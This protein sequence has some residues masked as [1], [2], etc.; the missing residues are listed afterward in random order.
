MSSS[1][2]ESKGSKVESSI[3]NS[4][5]VNESSQLSSV[6]S[7]GEESSGK[8]NHSVAKD[9][10]ESSS[11]V[12]PVIPIGQEYSDSMDDP[13]RQKFDAVKS[14]FDDTRKAK[15]QISWKGMTIRAPPR[16]GMCKKVPEGA[17]S[18]T[19]LDNLSGTVKPGQFLAII[20][21]S[22][23][24]KTTFLNYLS[25]RDP[26]KNLEKEGSIEIN[27]VDR[28]KFDYGKY[29]AYVQQDDVLYQTMTVK[30]CLTFAAEM[31]L[32]P[33]VDKEERVQSLM[34]S[35]RL[36]KAADTKIGG[37]LVK[38]VSGGERKRTSIGVELI[39]DPNLIFLDEPTTGLD[40]FTAQNVVEVLSS[41]AASGRT[42]ISTIHQPNSEIFE[43]FDQLML[44]AGGRT[45]YLNDA[46][47]AVQYFTK[48]GEVCPERTNPADFFMNMMSIEAM[49]EPDTE[50]QEEL[51]RTRTN[52]ETD[53]KKRIAMLSDKYKDSDLKCDGDSKHPEAKD[54]TSS[55]NDITK[56][57]P[58]LFKQFCLLILRNFKNIL[59]LPIASYGKV[60]SYLFVAIMI[61][62]VWGHLGEDEQSIQSRTGVLFMTSTMLIMFNVQGVILVFPD[63]RPVFIREHSGKMY[64]TTIYYIAKILSEVPL[65][66]IN[67][68]LYSVVL[69]W[70]VGLNTD[71]FGR[72]IVFWLY[73]ILL[74]WSAM[75]MG[76]A[77]G[78]L[79][80]DKNVAVGMIPVIIIPLML[81]SGFF[82]DQDN[83][84]PVLT[85]FE[86]ISLFKWSLQVYVYNEYE[87]L[88]LE[89][90]PSCDPLGDFD[91][92]ESKIVSI[93][94]T[95]VLGASFYLL[96][97]IFLHIIARMKA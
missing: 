88:T 47:K 15:L 35:L 87:G 71:S 4:Q 54:L 93:I 31:R 73:T 23:A 33:S 57:T 44:M 95:A 50:D 21:A 9:E 66:L 7:G 97:Y 43:G 94:V 14:S 18:V 1:Y 17:E 5:D 89:C 26:S 46:S 76:F 13:N 78:V 70:A 74:M 51:K 49:D 16:A 92:G 85:P 72:F 68:T 52:M 83:I 86:Y 19:I 64:D 65:T 37:P 2:E 80:S 8:G 61:L 11:R 79:V 81:L 42:I 30:E 58:N 3:E 36:E 77:G 12:D 69:Y 22:G 59:R 82:V 39:T 62:L 96:G 75:G 84:L 24:G 56:Y 38:G 10:E 32:P 45:L 60:I 55:E 25:G 29:V 63:E 67:G 41:L 91:F 53:Y 27:G 34:E 28:N 6:H 48:I 20:G 90:S 40:S